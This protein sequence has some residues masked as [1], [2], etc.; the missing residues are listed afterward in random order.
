MRAQHH[1]ALVWAPMS[2]RLRSCKNHGCHTSFRSC[3]RLV[4]VR[5]AHDIMVMD[6]GQIVEQGNHNSLVAAGGIYAK[7]VA[8]QTGGGLVS[9]IDVRFNN[10]LQSRFE[11]GTCSC[12]LR[13]WDVI[14][15]SIQLNRQCFTYVFDSSMSN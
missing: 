13:S 11:K 6:Q 4:T 12:G 2:G 9:S 5:N 10:A 7:M 15:L 3:Y 14:L 1:P 8:R